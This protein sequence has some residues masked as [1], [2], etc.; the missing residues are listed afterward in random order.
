MTVGL[1]RPPPVWKGSP[2]T[3]RLTRSGTQCVVIFPEEAP[4]AMEQLLST[5]GTRLY[6]I[7]S[8]DVSVMFQQAPEAKKKKEHVFGSHVRLRQLDSIHMCVHYSVH[9]AEQNMT[10]YSPCHPQ[11]AA[12]IDRKAN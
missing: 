1:M 4:P 11:R 8:N 6:S 7:C 3:T 5:A 10:Y 12:A 2:F 9:C